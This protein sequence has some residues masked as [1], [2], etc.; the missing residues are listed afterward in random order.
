MNN[1]ASVPPATVGFSLRAR[2]AIFLVLV[3]STCLSMLGLMGTSLFHHGVD[4]LGVAML[5]CFAITLPWTAIGFWNAAIGLVLMVFARNP[6]ALVAPHLQSIDGSEPVESRCAV[7]ICIRNEGTERLSRNLTWMLEGLIAS[8][9]ARWFHLYMLSDTSWEAVAA[10]EEALAQRLRERFGH[11]IS[12]TYRRRTERSGFKAGNMR[13]FCQ[14][15]AADHEYAIVLDADSLMTPAAMLRLVRIMQ[16]NPRI[17]ILQTLV[18]GLPSASAF[19]R[20]FQFGMRLGMRSYTLGAASWQGD[21]GP[22]WGHNAIL[23]LEPFSQHCDLPRLAGEPPLGGDVLSHDQVE[24]VLMRRSGYEVRV[25]PIEDGSFEENP[26]TLLEF[27]RRDLRWCQG[28][29]QYFQL[30]GLERLLPVSRIQLWL[31]IAM[32]ASAPAW[33]SFM[34]LGLIR[35]GGFRPDLG[36]ILLALTL[37]MGFAPKFATLAAVLLQS[38][39][40]E[41][42]GGAPR[43]LM[44]ALVELIFSILIVPICAVSVTVFVLG[45]PFGKQVGWTHQLRDSDGLP[46]KTA[47]RALWLHTLV[48]IGFAAWLWMVAPGALWIG[49]PFYIGLMISIP[50]AVF[51]A[52][53]ALGR[54]TGSIGLCL[55]PEETRRPERSEGTTLFEPFA[56][57]MVLK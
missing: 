46:W 35:Q 38:R 41:A 31:A 9:E 23:R 5:I 49:A 1:A 39:L 44:G 8:G 12:I 30:L 33:L 28:N 10:E 48:G 2:R 22:Y 3:L 14:R 17:G 20:V 24:A 21:C 42:F 32:Y 40:R 56:R 7:A 29:M 43:V 54:W 45:L 50:F 25:L 55:I 47:A 51:T 34:A 53:P 19:A 57:E 16:V 6:E 37:I 13:D 18:T 36:A 4:T 11:A 15:W 27:I 52:S 26:P